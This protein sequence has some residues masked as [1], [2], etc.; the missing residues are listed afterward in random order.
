MR[1]KHH[2][3]NVARRLWKKMPELLQALESAPDALR[4]RMMAAA[5]PRPAESAYAS[6]AH[7]REQ[8]GPD[9]A[10]ALVAP[11]LVLLAGVVAL[12]AVRIPAALGWLGVVSGFLWL[13]VRLLRARNS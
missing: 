5:E 1:E 6:D 7:R 12:S 11:A 9:P 13:M 8:R 4:Q 10:P 2:P 3:L